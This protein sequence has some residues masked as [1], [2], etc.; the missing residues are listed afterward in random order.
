MSRILS[1]FVHTT[2]ETRAQSYSQLLET[3]TSKFFG[4]A[5]IRYQQNCPLLRRVIRSSRRGR[6]LTTSRDIREHLTN[7]VFHEVERRSFFESMRRNG[8]GKS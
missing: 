1:V 2:V 5:T 6:A 4:S 3:P 7:G 8:K